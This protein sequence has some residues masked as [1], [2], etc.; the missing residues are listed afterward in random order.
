MR[1][2]V[3]REDVGGDVF[4]GLAVAPRGG[5]R[6][7]AVL[8]QQRHREP[9]ELGLADEAHRIGDH[10]LDASVPREQ[11]VA[12]ERV[13]EREHAHVVADRRERGRQ[14]PT[15]LFERGTLPELRVLRLQRFELALELVVLAVGDLRLVAVVALA[16]VPDELGE[17]RGAVRDLRRNA[18]LPVRGH[19]P[20]STEPV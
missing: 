10:P 14:H 13:V 17:R 12:V 1:D 11:L 2:A 18:V 8:V 7:A 9:V 16:V 15:H 4:A 19:Q 5:A 3:D 20:Q 6:E